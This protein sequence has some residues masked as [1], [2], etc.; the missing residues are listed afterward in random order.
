MSSE[1]GAGKLRG[2][3]GVRGG[4]AALPQRA[5][6][7]TQHQ[8]VDAAAGNVRAVGVRCRRALGGAR[9]LGVRVGGAHER[10]ET[11]QERPR[12]R[13]HHK[14]CTRALRR[15]GSPGLRGAPGDARG[16]AARSGARRRR[17]PRSAARVFCFARRRGTVAL[18][19]LVVRVP[20]RRPARTGASAASS[21]AASATTSSTSSCWPASQRPVANASAH[22]AGPA[23]PRCGGGERHQRLA[24]RAFEPRRVRRRRRA[25]TSA[26]TSGAAAETSSSGTARIKPSTAYTAPSAASARSTA[27]RL[28]A[29]SSPPRFCR[30]ASTHRNKPSGLGRDATRRAAAFAALARRRDASG[31]S[32]FCRTRHH[33][34]G[35]RFSF[36]VVRPRPRRR[37]R[38]CP[39]RTARTPR[40]RRCRRCRRCPPRT[41][42]TPPRRRRRART[43][44]RGR[45]RRY[46]RRR[47]RC[48]SVPGS[49]PA[50]PRLR[51]EGSLRLRRPPA[52]R[53]NA[54][55]LC[56]SLFFS[57]DASASSR[58]SK[59]ASPRSHSASSSETSPETPSGSRNSPTRSPRRRRTSAAAR[60]QRQRQRRGHLAAVTPRVGVRRV[61]ARA[62][63]AHQRRR[64]HQDDAAA[65]APPRVHGHAPG[66]P[67]PRS[68]RW[69][70]SCAARLG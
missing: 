47:L 11:R 69:P 33:H 54:S 40:T 67:P 8:R 53:R 48:G 29:D 57:S 5:Q 58:N 28:E 39:C 70:R 59:T 50:R 9:R 2:V 62:H 43:R 32:P 35:P 27:D 60:G 26:E 7:A 37:P 65:A 30:S 63:A 18:V 68:R 20:Q 45:R 46:A 55:S 14:M 64:A 22:S 42:R 66:A 17:A 10:A 4:G 25:C 6:R 16:S 41:K 15:P 21:R 52:T 3:R 61:Q 44:R 12:E 51:P 24:P 1:H 23:M 34:C 38:H 36:F 31:E 49:R 13:I 56:S 19:V